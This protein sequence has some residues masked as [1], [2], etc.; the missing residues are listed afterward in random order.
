MRHT[1]KSN[2]TTQV[3]KPPSTR[4]QNNTVK[5]AESKEHESMHS[6]NIISFIAKLL[7]PNR[8][9]LTAQVEPQADDGKGYPTQGDEGYEKAPLC[10]T[11]SRRLILGCC[12]WL[13]GPLVVWVNGKI[14]SHDL[15]SSRPQRSLRCGVNKPS[16]FLNL[17]RATPGAGVPCFNER[18]IIRSGST[19]SERL[20]T[21]SVPGLQPDQRRCPL[22]LTFLHPCRFSSR[23]AM[24]S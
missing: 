10:R 11:G 24:R 8:R 5:Q 16:E 3:T 7:N 2:P 9:Q 12:R 13:Q 6:F 23:V 15:I 1:N 20:M 21:L 14:A 22:S 4:H 18:I 19:S 17:A